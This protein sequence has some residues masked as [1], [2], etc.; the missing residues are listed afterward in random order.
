MKKMILAV[1]LSSC[2]AA[3]YAGAAEF[4]SKENAFSIQIPEK[5][6]RKEHV[7]GTV[8]TAIAPANPD[9]KDAFRPNANV[10]AQE[11]PSDTDLKK[12]ADGTLTAMS[13][14]LKNY[15]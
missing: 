1:A 12:F 5:W 4:T 8:V 3:M 13:K 7:S 2:M 6:E 15:K 10:N 14:L 9:A 11:I